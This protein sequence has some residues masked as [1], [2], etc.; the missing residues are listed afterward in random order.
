MLISATIVVFAARGLLA[1]HP[2]RPDPLNTARVVALDVGIC[3]ELL[4]A[5]GITAEG[6][7]SLLARIADA[8]EATAG[9][10][11][12]QADAALAATQLAA[13]R[14]LMSSDGENP[15]R[16]AELERAEAELARANSQI[17][18]SVNTIWTAA[19]AGLEGGT[20][21]LFQSFRFAAGAGVP[22]TWKV[23]PFDAERWH[24]VEHA[25]IAE[26]RAARLNQELPQEQ[27][28]LLAEVRATGQ[29]IEA[30]QRFAGLFPQVAEQF[31]TR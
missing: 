14:D 2:V 15:E 1:P 23:C 6:A 12:A 17:E 10:R 24:S 19:T 16:R 13:A 20:N 18:A 3:P 22:A 30:E 28:R 29:L 26:R 5:T 8:A 9:L 7:A 21:D 4:A 27:S 25:L 31:V 11:Q